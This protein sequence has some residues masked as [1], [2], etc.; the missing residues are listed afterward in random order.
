MVIH[1]AAAITHCNSCAVR[2]GYLLIEVQIHSWQ[3][4]VA[5]TLNTHKL[6]YGICNSA[7]SYIMLHAYMTGLVEMY[8]LVLFTAKVDQV[9]FDITELHARPQLAA[10][11][12]MADDASGKVEVSQCFFFVLRPHM[13]LSVLSIQLAMVLRWCRFHG[14]S[15]PLPTETF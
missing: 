10:E 3:N 12:R 13:K 2:W 14:L 4:K 8:I 11:Q 6:A 7:Q 15:H 9:K 5:D 1:R